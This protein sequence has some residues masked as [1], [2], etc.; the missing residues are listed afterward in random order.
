MSQAMENRLKTVRNNLGFTQ[1]E[2]ANVVDT[3][4][5]QIQRLEA[6]KRRLSDHWLI[7][8]ANGLK[9]DPLELLIDTQTLPTASE[10]AIL[11]AYN[12]SPEH[13]QK[14]IKTLLGVEE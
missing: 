10:M 4:K 3:S 6:G 13:V 5:Q 2:V 14:T 11:K 9:I 7:R 1:E 8:I 12:D